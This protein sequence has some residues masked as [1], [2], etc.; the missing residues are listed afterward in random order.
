MHVI[1]FKD[2]FMEQKVTHDHPLYLVCPYVLSLVGERLSGEGC[3]SSNHI[4]F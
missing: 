2:N 3:G 1:K 4:Q